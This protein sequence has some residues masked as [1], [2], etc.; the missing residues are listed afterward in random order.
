MSCEE[1]PRG[2]C[3]CHVTFFVYSMINNRY[4]FGRADLVISGWDVA[5]L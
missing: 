1:E 4:P 5:L 2:Q 3:E